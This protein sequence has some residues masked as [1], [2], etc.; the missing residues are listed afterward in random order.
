[1]SLQ[2]IATLILCAALSLATAGCAGSAG[3]NSPAQSGTDQ[4]QSFGE[5]LPSQ[6][7]GDATSP[8][9]G[10]EATLYLGT[11]P[12][13]FVEYPLSYDGELTPELLIGGISSLTGWDLA[14][15]GPVSTGKDGM[16]VCFATDGV[17]FA[18][19]PDP[20][21][22]EFH[23]FDAEDLARHI[24]DSI[25]KTLQMNFVAPGGDPDS[26]D[27]YYLME[28]E[29]PLTLPDAGLSWAIDQPYQWDAATVGQASGDMPEQEGADDEALQYLADMLAD[30]YGGISGL[31]FL[32]NGEE[33][34][35]G[36]SCL[37]FKVG[38]DHG[39]RIESLG[40]YAV[41][42]DLS[43]LYQFDMITA[44]YKEYGQG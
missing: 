1:M 34:I 29:L 42:S 15:S 21:K 43:G 22:P 28:G 38:I 27:V 4:P 30:E 2:K 35:D 40:F 33:E 14:L 17:L 11:G 6:P 8:V 23:V 12:D 44:E 5:A 20:Q 31:V 19:P 18:G 16:T 37:L 3:A 26:L 36:E 32:P 41:K 9:Q 25:Q 39:D 7:T 10:Q 13:D 24:L